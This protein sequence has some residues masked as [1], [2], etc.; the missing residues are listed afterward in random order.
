MQ[1]MTF[2]TKCILIKQKLPIDTGPNFGHIQKL[3]ISHVIKFQ[4]EM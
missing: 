1:V 3:P 4:I 2:C